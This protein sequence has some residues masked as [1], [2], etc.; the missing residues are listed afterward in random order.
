VA[1]GVAY[2]V[3]VG[4]A[5]GVGVTI[6]W[7][8][9]VVL[10]PF[11]RVWNTLLY[12]LDKRRTG[13]KP[14]LLRWHSAFWDE[15]Q[16]LPLIGLDKYVVLVMERNPTEGRAALNYLSY[17]STSRQRWAAQAAQIEL[18]ARELERCA[19]VKAIKNAHKSL[20]VGNLESP[21]ST[22]LHSFSHI[23]ENVDAALNQGTTYNQRLALT[24]VAEQLR[25]LIRELTRSSEKYADRFLP[26][27]RHWCEIVSHYV[28][29]LAQT[30]ELRQA[31]KRFNLTP[32]NPRST[33]D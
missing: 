17:L 26:I 25:G 5:A 31:A 4:V 10:Y 28:Q 11:L 6:N 18:D 16:R 8:R 1:Y 7:W 23:S 15:W 12:Q 29:E 20:T 30:I 21:A 3:A 2:G 22:L 32:P 9:P 19:D 14:S 24:P 13:S 33:S 27:A